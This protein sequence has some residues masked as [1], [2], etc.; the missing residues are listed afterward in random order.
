MTNRQGEYSYR[1]AE[2]EEEIQ[3]RSSACLSAVLVQPVSRLGAWLLS[4]THARTRVL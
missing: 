3:R 4:A 1:F 2:K